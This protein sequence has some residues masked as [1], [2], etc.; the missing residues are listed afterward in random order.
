MI[1]VPKLCIYGIKG[2]TNKQKIFICNLSNTIHYS[3]CSSN[4]IWVNKNWIQNEVVELAHNDHIYFLDPTK[5]GIKGTMSDIKKN[6]L[7]LVNNKRQ[8][9]ENPCY[10]FVKPQLTTTKYDDIFCLY[11]VEKRIGRGAFGEVFLA[12]C[13][14]TKKNVA[15]KVIKSEVWDNK[16]LRSSLLRE[17]SVCMSFPVHV[18]FEAIEP[19][20]NVLDILFL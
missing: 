11:R 12:T 6:W 18:S 20:Y 1:Y 13:K 15:M 7:K 4:G 5:Y 8:I 9:L 17:I 2:R 14:K 16:R 19:W 10:T 3:M